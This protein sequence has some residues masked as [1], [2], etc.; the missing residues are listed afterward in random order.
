MI[1][2]TKVNYS[3]KDL[4]KAGLLSDRG[5][6]QKERL[7]GVLGEYFGVKHILLTPSGRGGFYY[8]LRALSQPRVIV[9]AYTCKAVVE[10]A[11]LAGKEVVFVEIESDGFN[12]D[13]GGLQKVVDEKSVVLATHQFGIPCQIERIQEICK[14]RRALVIED[15]AASFGSRISGRLTGTF[16]D[17]AF[18]SFDSTKTI[19]VPLKGGFIT[20]K[21]GD[22]FNRIK[23]IYKAET[24]PMPLV[25]KLKLLLLGLSYLLIE[26]H[27]LYSL[28]H[29][30]N[31]Q[32]RGAFTADNDRLSLTRNMFYR[33]ELAEWQAYFA[34]KQV[35][36]I[37]EIIRKRR[38][39]YS[40]Y[41]D[42]L[43]G[44]KAFVLPPDDKASQ[45]VCTRFPILVK[46]DKLAYYRKAVRLGVDFAFSFTFIPAPEEFD[47]AHRLADAVLDI[48]FYWKLRDEEFDSVVKVLQT[49]E[50]RDQ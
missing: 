27:S 40:K 29:L 44:C 5:Q 14:A 25:T 9:P 21:N 7:R 22:L 20:S 11:R 23:R 8:I 37:D 12:M 39:I 13:P 19:N 28:F 50:Q 2:R 1:P 30:I 41:R 4:V 42:K 36:H 47:H 31:F 6:E 26:N 46:G 45:W 15:A 33:W 32:L 38:E 16:G 34:A 3:L 10:A 49:L 24:K 17:A 48:P 18:F 43:S 35:E